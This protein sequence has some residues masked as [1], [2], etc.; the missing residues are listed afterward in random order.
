MCDAAIPDLVVILPCAGEGSRLGLNDPKPLFEL[1]PG[2]RLVDLTLE[3]LYLAGRKGIDF[4]V[5]T[6]VSPRTTAV[7]DYVREKLRGRRVDMCL[8]N[9]AYRE[10][11]GSVYSASPGFGDLNLVMLPDSLLSLSGESPGFDPNGDCLLRKM[12]EG[13]RRHP[14]HFMVAPER[15]SRLRR[16]G[17]VRVDGGKVRVLADKPDGDLSRYNGFWAAYGFRRSHGRDLYL[18]LD[19]LVGKRSLPF[20]LDRL[21]P[22][23]AVDIHEY[24][25]LG[26]WEDIAEFRRC[27][28]DGEGLFCSPGARRS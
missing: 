12:L 5:I 25:D 28:P 19:A 4:R 7:F 21:G 20:P 3:H 24:R 15:S 27:H 13:L 6:V 8:F 23:G 14:V 2:L 17:A 16:L 1:L 10:W 22:P 26:T 11:P 18:Y 9:D